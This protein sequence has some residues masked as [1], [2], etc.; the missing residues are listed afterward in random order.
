MTTITATVPTLSAG[1][2]E[3]EIDG[4]RYSFIELEDGS[5][6]VAHGHQDPTT[7][8]TEVNAYDVHVGGMKEDDA[9]VGADDVA[10][11]YAKHLNPDADRDEW[12]ITWRGITETT[13]GAFPI[14]VVSR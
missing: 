14:T 2:F 8:A 12:Q 3:T 13:P 5:T 6:I 4:H 10:H 7:F 11:L 1:D 9:E